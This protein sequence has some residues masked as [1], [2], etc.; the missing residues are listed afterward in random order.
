[1]ATGQ[2]L[3]VGRA[4]RYPQAMTTASRSIASSLML[5][6]AALALGALSVLAWL[7]G[8]V[9]GMIISGVSGIT[10]VAL[11]T[12]CALRRSSDHGD[13]GT[14]VWAIALGTLGLA[15]QWATHVAMSLMPV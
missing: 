7:I 15:G 2:T 4:Q 13:K 12:A 9:P 11:G 6:I 14:A 8:G 10:A 3:A 5:P 1:M